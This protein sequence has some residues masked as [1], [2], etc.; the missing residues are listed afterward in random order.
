[1]TENPQLQNTSE[2][3]S[4]PLKRL[5]P[6]F[7]YSLKSLWFVW[8][9][10][11]VLL[12]MHTLYYFWI[13]SGDASQYIIQK[14]YCLIGLEAVMVV[15]GVALAS[16]SRFFKFNVT[17][18][19]LSLGAFIIYFFAYVT[20]AQFFDTPRFGITFTDL[21][22]AFTA[23]IFTGVYCGFRICGEELSTL[24]KEMKN[25]FI[26]LGVA[27]L[28][29]L[30]IAFCLD[31]AEF[32]GMFF[33]YIAVIIFF[34]FVLGR[35]F[36]VLIRAFSRGSPVMN[37]TIYAII[38]VILP[39][40][41]FFVLMYKNTG[42]I[43]KLF[44]DL[45]FF[46]FAALL[47]V[48]VLLFYKKFNDDKIRA[49]FLFLNAM[50]F[51]VIAFVAYLFLPTFPFISGMVFAIAGFWVLG[52]LYS[53]VYCL[54]GFVDV[55]KSVRSKSL[56]NIAVI[57]GFFALPAYICIEPY[58]LRIAISEA[59]NYVECPD[60]S[61]ER[62]FSGSQWGVLRTCKLV[63]SFKKNSLNLPYIGE[64]RSYIFSN[65]MVLR[66]RTLN[67][68]ESLFAENAGESLADETSRFKDDAPIIP[69]SGVVQS[70]KFSPQEGASLD[71][72]KIELEKKFKG[73]SRR[74]EASC[75]VKLSDGVFVA[76]MSM[77]VNGEEKSATFAER[78]AAYWVYENVTRQ[79][80]D[81]SIIYYE[82]LSDMRLR[83]APLRNGEKKCITLNFLYP[84]EFSTYKILL[85]DSVK[86]QET[87]SLG[88]PADADCLI[89][90][91]EEASYLLIK[92]T[93]KFYS[94][95][96]RP[97]WSII[98][99]LSKRSTFEDLEKKFAELSKISSD[100]VK[101]R[102]YFSDLNFSYALEVSFKDSK[103]QLDT[104]KTA[105]EYHESRGGFNATISH[106]FMMSHYAKTAFKEG[107]YGK[108]EF[109]ITVFFSDNI[110]GYA[111][112]D[113]FKEFLP[114]LD[115]SYAIVVG[116]DGVQTVSEKPLDLRKPPFANNP[117][118]SLFKIASEMR[119]VK[120]VPENSFDAVKEFVI[121]EK[122]DAA[123]VAVFD[124][125]YAAKQIDARSAKNSGWAL[126]ANLRAKSILSKRN[127]AFGEINFK[128]IVNLSEY[129]KVL[130]PSTSAII[131]EMS[132]HEKLLYLA[133]IKSKNSHSALDFKTD[134]RRT[135][136]EP[137]FY[138]Y[139]IFAFLIC[140]FMKM[141]SRRNKKLKSL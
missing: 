78:K 91:G 38:C 107:A 90:C 69:S 56:R 108:E 68:I 109:P 50:S 121:S 59:L 5:L 136:D 77:S 119:P 124:A 34:D 41:C 116:K 44:E 101:A 27:V 87:T 36:L 54:F 97:Y 135:M 100:I 48:L 102:I 98:L 47:N 76:G 45:G 64:L 104:L 88:K 89:A 2:I 122:V 128:N 129:L 84:P 81:P 61:K 105:L 94:Y 66:A 82:N 58:C 126:A 137:E 15:V 134:N 6:D 30:G 72:C 99:D 14:A 13:N 133:D 17:M 19:F 4:K 39:M 113:A 96:R 18:A 1:M 127:P 138:L 106:L 110:N 63:E 23:I 74:N 10:P 70:C 3:E 115:F 24:K 7:F 131:L 20:N 11:Q 95:E 12:L 103:W 80:I 118:I 21:H 71:V 32:V 86:N 43:L 140:A 123:D 40:I 67:K 9:L 51:S 8:V 92:N 141:I 117:K 31:I 73:E 28:L 35:T 111:P 65:G 22:F 60:T 83:V 52:L 112:T 53:F 33:F 26:V 37:I 120:L 62:Y 55:Y 93:G 125:S 46:I 29:A 49:L 130:A 114:E 25:I 75:K 85:E 139:L 132:S 42:E 57:L 16:L 79:N